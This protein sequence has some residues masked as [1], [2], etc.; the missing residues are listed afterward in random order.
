[1][2]ARRLRFCCQLKSLGDALGSD[3]VIA[4]VTAGPLRRWPAFYRDDGRRNEDWYGWNASVLAPF[5]GIVDSVHIA[6]GRPTGRA[7][8]EGSG[9]A[10][11]CSGAPMASGC[12]MRTC[13]TSK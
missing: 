12:F 8:S 1:M 6:R 2:P 5:D 7:S 3:C 9:L 4:S 11:L 10:A 13:K